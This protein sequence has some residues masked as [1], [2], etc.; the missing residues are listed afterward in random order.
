MIAW[1]R[2]TLGRV[3]SSLVEEW[4]RLLHGRDAAEAEEEARPL[5]IS[6]DLRAFSARIRAELHRLVQALAR[7]DYEEAAAHVRPSEEQPWGAERV[8]AELAPYY[9]E[10]ERIVFDHAARL[11]HHTHLE[12]DGP[13]RWRVAQ[14]LVDP[15]GD[16]LWSLRGV[17]DL[18]EDTAPAGPLVELVA[19]S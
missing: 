13:H 2:T 16:G 4:E 19:I 12:P 10:Y 11:A 17:V 9:E 6:A 8:E 7:Q 15:A 1:L 5:D 18:K 14:T 3:D